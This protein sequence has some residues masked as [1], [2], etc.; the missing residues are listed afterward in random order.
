[1]DTYQFN[2]MKG[3]RLLGSVKV[4]ARVTRLFNNNNAPNG[5]LGITDDGLAYVAV[6]H[7]KRTEMR[8]GKLLTKQLYDNEKVKFYI[9]KLKSVMLDI[10]Q[11]EVQFTSDAQEIYD[12]YDDCNFYSCMQGNESVKAYGGPDTALAYILM[13][14]KPVA[15]AI[16]S[17]I[18]KVYVRAYGFTTLIESKLEELGYVKGDLNG[19]RLLKIE[20]DEQSYLCPYLDCDTKH[21]DVEEDYLVISRCGE[22]DSNDGT[23]GIIGLIKCDCC[24]EGVIRD[25]LYYV[26]CE[27]REL[28]SDC[29]NSDYVW[30]NYELIRREDAYEY[31]G[32]WYDAE[33][34]DEIVFSIDNEYRHRDEVVWSDYESEYILDENAVHLEYKE[35]YCLKEDATYSEYTEEW[36]L[37]EDVCT[38]VTDLDYPEGEVVLEEDTTEYRNVRYH[39]DIVDEVEEMQPELD[40]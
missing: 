24:G 5:L 6:D 10:D 40:L 1:M 21:V 29:V 17:L 16:I 18:E 28:C 34:D 3:N 27:N 4:D 36:Y 22:F 11:A 13:D 15:R 38:A 30:A 25:E 32:E 39:D 33:N 2:D 35:D 7:E 8:L 19:H 23:S 9:E 12:I 37:D 20:N 26:E 31:N 14:G